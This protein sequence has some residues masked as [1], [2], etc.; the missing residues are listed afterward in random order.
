MTV[1]LYRGRH[2]I[3]ATP[4]V[5]KEQPIMTTYLS[6]T[7]GIDMSR[8]LASSR[9]TKKWL[10]EYLRANPQK[11]FRIHGSGTFVNGEDCI[12]EDISLEV[13]NP[14]TSELV[15]AVEFQAV[16]RTEQ[17]PWGYQAVVR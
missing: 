6:V 15:A 1:Y 16:E 5:R 8:D 13:R 11:D 9:L 7:P 12:R 4:T 10:R 2:W 3:V 17:N 14:A